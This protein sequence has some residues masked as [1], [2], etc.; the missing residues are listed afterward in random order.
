MILAGAVIAHAEREELGIS[1]TPFDPD[2][3]NPASY[4]LTLGD[5]LCVYCTSGV[6]R[7]REGSVVK[8]WT[9]LPL[10][11]P[12]LDTKQPNPFYRA[13]ISPDGFRLGSSSDRPRVF[14]LHTVQVIAPGLEHVAVVDGKSSLGRLGLVVHATAGYVDPGFRGQIT[15]ECV[16]LGEDVIVYP[17][18][19]IA[20]VRFARLG[21]T[22]ET[23]R[24]PDEG[25][26]SYE[27]SGHYIGNLA[28]GPVPSMSYRQFDR[29][30]KT[31]PI[32]PPTVCYIDHGSLRRDDYT[33]AVTC[34]C[35]GPVG[36]L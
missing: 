14:L 7:S 13:R 25:H 1:I 34:P 9:Q 24:L 36:R 29:A 22:Q 8:S 20:Q 28:T 16:A 17:G 11:P 21:F 31:D 4:D 19:R 10:P 27:L 35:C 30:V 5:E 3:V 12:A 23:R 32:P 26:M 15:L 18:M 33:N 6:D 2:L